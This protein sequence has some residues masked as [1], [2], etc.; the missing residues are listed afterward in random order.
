VNTHDS[1]RIS[2][3][4]EIRTFFGKVGGRSLLVKGTAGTGKTT[5]ALQLLE[6]LAD[7]D[8]SIYL[9]TR[10]SDEALF[11]QFPWLR[12]KEM[13]G[14]IIDASRVLLQKL[15]PEEGVDEEQEREDMERLS[16]AREFLRSVSDE[17]L[18]PPSKVSKVHL[19]KLKDRPPGELPEIERLYENVEDNLPEKSMLVIDSV[20]GISNRY[21]IESDELVT[22]IQK[23]LV[24]MSNADVLFV[25]E[26]TEAKTV[27]FL[28]DGVIRFTHGVK[29]GR[30]VREVHLEKLRATQIYQPSYLITL[31]E[32]RFTSFDPF[33]LSDIEQP[34]TWEPIPDTETHYSTGIKTLDKLLTGGYTPGSYNVIEVDENV[35]GE[36]YYSVIRPILLN[37]L[38]QDK[39]IF[40]VLS[41]GDHAESFRKDMVRFIPEDI[42]ENSVRIADYFIPR[43]NS[44]YVMALGTRNKDEALRVWKS[45][46]EALRGAENRPII[47]YTGFDTL[48]YI[49][50]GGVAIKQLLDAVAKIKIS[51][52][53]GI[54]VLKPGLKLT[55]E[56]MNMADT[57][58]KIS[59]INRCP[60]LYGIK[61]KTMIFGIVNDAEL[62]PP[63][64]RLVPIV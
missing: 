44:P 55:Q 38:S 58:L 3:P 36:E 15:H 34:I 54:G 23:D 48:E 62:G 1:N 7:P 49:Q 2:I 51:K 16:S 61:P 63:H 17:P 37:F 22:C 27:E 20:E 53:I 40:A 24:E 39:G 19:S 12:D 60:C 18:A 59:S 5:F 52:D 31:K 28:V 50:G 4:R 9:S 57:Y 13:R 30:R 10:V 6:E 64:I 11:Q 41:G 35:S 8:R 25:L 56:I 26:D 46:Q 29:E 14:R 32:G 47:D 42:F 45:N 43:S 21:S 33:A